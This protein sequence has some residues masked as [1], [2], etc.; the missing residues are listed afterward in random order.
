MMDSTSVDVLVTGDVYSDLIF[1]GVKIPRQGTETFAQNFTISP[2]GAA[3]RAVASARIGADTALLSAMG[4][5]PI[6]SIVRQMLSTENNLDM[7]QT[8]C[9]TGVTNPV[10]AAIT[11]GSDR[12]FVTFHTDNPQPVWNPVRSVRTVMLPAEEE[13]PDWAHR[14]HEDGTT[15]FASVGWDPTGEWSDSLLQRLQSFDVLMLNDAE[16]KGYSHRDDLNEA[17]EIFSEVVPTTVITLG[18][19]GAMAASADGRSAIPGIAVDAKDP[20]GAGD[21]FSAAFM[22]GTAW[23]WPIDD[24][25]QLASAC[26]AYSVT[27]PGGAVSA[28]RRDQ[29]SEFLDA[30]HCNDEDWSR[31]L[32][33]A[34]SRDRPLGSS[35][36][37]N[38]SLDNSSSPNNN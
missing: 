5:D 9:L 11:D 32:S 10:S 37:D 36:D 20:T 23:N 1:S 6:G 4:D 34:D 25:L 29:L 19:G 30:H 31:L 13:V 7:T 28:P 15:L 18:S 22:A 17:L 38:S 35:L 26:A 21:I 12:S 24:C 3:N 2:G 27:Q 14:L 16:A 33:W 8:R